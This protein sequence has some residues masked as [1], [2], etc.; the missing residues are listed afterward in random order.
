MQ[1][2]LLGEGRVL[3]HGIDTVGMFFSPCWLG[4]FKNVCINRT[5]NAFYRESNTQILS[6]KVN[7][8]RVDH[9]KKPLK[10]ISS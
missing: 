9:I 2:T 6:K 5:L 10:N 1:D 4:L 3:P 8:L 7:F